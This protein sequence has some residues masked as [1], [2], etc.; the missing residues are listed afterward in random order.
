MALKENRSKATLI[1]EQE[2]LQKTPVALEG[3]KNT[4]ILST[5]H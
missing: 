4:Y 3:W 5:R 1:R 2:L